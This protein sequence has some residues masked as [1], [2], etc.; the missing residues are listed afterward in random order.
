MAAP[1][2]CR[3]RIWAAPC[4]G[5]S[6]QSGCGGNFRRDDEM[7]LTPAVGL[8]VLNPLNKPA[9][10]GALAGFVLRL[11]RTKG[12]GAERQKGL[13]TK[14]WP[15]CDQAPAPGDTRLHA[16]KRRATMSGLSRLFS[17]KCHPLS[18]REPHKPTKAR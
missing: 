7:N 10:L 2:R 8:C 17:Q 15:R 18:K 9:T 13:K 16:D 6:S 4:A 11:F 1:G 14:E 5:C 12:S 3:W